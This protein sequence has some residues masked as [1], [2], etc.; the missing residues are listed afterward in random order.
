M[1]FS[2]ITTDEF[3][4]GA[5]EEKKKDKVLHWGELEEGKIYAVLKLEKVSHPKYGDS[6]IFHIQDQTGENLKVWGPKRLSSKILEERPIHHNT[7]VASLGFTE[8]ETA[9]GVKKKEYKWDI[10]FKYDRNAVVN[11]LV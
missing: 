11:Y 2:F 6:Y 5:A 3:S 1:A 9:K 10:S 8:T 4:L 7:F